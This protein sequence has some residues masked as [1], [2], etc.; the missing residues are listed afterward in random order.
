MNVLRPLSGI[1]AA[2]LPLRNNAFLGVLARSFSIEGNSGEE[3][4]MT[5]E[6]SCDILAEAGRRGLPEPR[7]DLLSAEDPARP[8]FPSRADKDTNDDS[9]EVVEARLLNITDGTAEN[10]IVAA[11]A[12]QVSSRYWMMGGIDKTNKITPCCDRCGELEAKFGVLSHHEPIAPSRD[13]AH[14]LP[15]LQL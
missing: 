5:I 6:S 11:F 10:R 4:I 2:W 12:F 9:F 13:A 7:T 3:E 1:G 8:A 15:H 14:D